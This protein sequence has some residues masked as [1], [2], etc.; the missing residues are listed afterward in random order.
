MLVDSPDKYAVFP[1]PSASVVVDPSPSATECANAAFALEPNAM[2][3]AAVAFANVPMA[4]ELSPDAVTLLVSFTPAPIPMAF[5]P[6]KLTKYPR[7]APALAP[8]STVLRAP[9]LTA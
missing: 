9:T 1:A 6:D 3:L 7:A 4:A 8:A 5:L 2:A